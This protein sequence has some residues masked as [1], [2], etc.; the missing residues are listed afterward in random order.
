[1]GKESDKSD[2]DTIKSTARGNLSRMFD[3]ANNDSLSSGILLLSNASSES[4]TLSIRKNQNTT[5]SSIG[6]MVLFQKIRGE[7]K[8]KPI[9]LEILICG[10]LICVCPSIEDARENLI[11][12]LYDFSSVI[13]TQER[14]Q[15][16]PY[17]VE[18]MEI[19]S[20]DKRTYKNVLYK[21]NTGVKLLELAF[22]AVDNLLQKAH[23]YIKTWLQFQSLWDL[24]PDTLYLKLNNNL[25]AIISCLNEMKDSRQSFD[26]QETQ[27]FF[28][29]ISVDYTNVQYEVNVKYDAWHKEV[30]G[31]CDSLLGMDLDSAN[32]FKDFKQSD[33]A[34]AAAAPT[35]NRQKKIDS[36]SEEVIELDNS[37]LDDLDDNFKPTKL[38]PRRARVTPKI[39]HP[40]RRRSPTSRWRT[41]F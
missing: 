35:N 10:Q 39:S 11:S 34:K 4:L 38:T 22:S 14:I 13:T 20:K 23:N 26:T 33:A 8:I 28:G 18:I 7:P 25:N 12:Q 1:M 29:P 21:F 31:K 30:L 6:E 24:Q 16:T 17:Q 27:R 3:D 15:H 36:Y 40:R 9:I 32:N 5:N 2:D 19:E 37:D 41:Y